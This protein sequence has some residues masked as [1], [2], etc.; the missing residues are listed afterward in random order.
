MRPK[1]EPDVETTVKAFMEKNKCKDVNDALKLAFQK[2]QSLEQQPQPITSDVPL[3][4][5]QNPEKQKAME[6]LKEEY[7]E[8]TELP[9]PQCN[10][11]GKGY[12]DHKLGVQ[13]VYCDNPKKYKKPTAIPLPSCQTCWKRKEWGK[14]KREREQE[15]KPYQEPE[16]QEETE[17]PKCSHL[18]DGTVY[19]RQATDKLKE[20]PVGTKLIY[21]MDAGFWKTLQQCLQCFK[22]GKTPTPTTAIDISETEQ[23]EIT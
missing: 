23:E 10:F 11:C 18:K 3:G 9:L 16:E 5:P 13:F 2:L 17:P 15:E 20:F 1:I 8:V 12:I 7:Y 19:V 21:C 4:E 14:E 22:G 6:K